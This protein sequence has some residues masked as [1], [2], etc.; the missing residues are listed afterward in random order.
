MATTEHLLE[1]TERLTRRW[2]E[3]DIDGV[4]A[5]Y[6]DDVLYQEVGAGL[7]IQGS[8][9]LRRYL[10]GY[11]K[12]WDGRWTIDGHHRLEGQDAILV[13]WNMEVWRSGTD[14]R[15]NTR[16]MDIVT[17]RGDRV[18]RDVVYFDRMQL[19]PLMKE[20]A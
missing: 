11:F 15:I 9:K 1:V 5:Y 20:A 19:L 13:T 12:A 16:G 7:T 6:T 2:D 4:L 3:R 17:V 8:E 14:R 18:C 10:L